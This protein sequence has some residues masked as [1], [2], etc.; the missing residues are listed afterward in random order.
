MSKVVRAVVVGG[1]RARYWSQVSRTDITRHM[2]R[3][4]LVAIAR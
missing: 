2:Q 1:G 4:I 3:A